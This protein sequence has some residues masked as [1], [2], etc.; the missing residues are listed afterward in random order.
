[1]HVLAFIL[2]Q[3]QHRI[4]QRLGG[5]AVPIL[6]GFTADFGQACVLCANH[7]T[8]LAHRFKDRQAEAFEV[9]RKDKSERFAVQALELVVGDI[10]AMLNNTTA[11][12]IRNALPDG[13][14]LPT[15]PA[16]QAKLSRTIRS[17]PVDLKRI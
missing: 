4:S 15:F 8:G 2:F 16:G 5:F 17:L 11:L 6:D 10:P 13:L 1:M 14:A 3:L 12:K 9:T 7:R